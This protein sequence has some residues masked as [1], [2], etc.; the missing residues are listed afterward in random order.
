MD[1]EKLKCLWEK[2]G[3]KRFQLWEHDA[4]GGIRVLITLHAESPGPLCFSTGENILCNL[5]S[6][7]AES[8]LAD[9]SQDR[10]RGDQGGTPDRRRIESQRGVLDSLIQSLFIAL[11]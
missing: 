10:L 2:E 6:D 5:A 4:K 9:D 8:S 3:T 7:T 11:E 1:W